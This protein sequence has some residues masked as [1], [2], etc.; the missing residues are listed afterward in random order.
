MNVAN[1]PSVCAGPRT[2]ETLIYHEFPG[3]PPRISIALYAG[4]CHSCCE[5]RTSSMLANVP[6]AVLR[7]SSL[8]QAEATERSVVRRYLLHR[9][10]IGMWIVLT[11]WRKPDGST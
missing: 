8:E 7:I 6:V 9:L 2:G 3:D 10:W 4:F 1:R 11:A 5:E